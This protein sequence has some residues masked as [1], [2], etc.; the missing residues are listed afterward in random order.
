MESV[1]IGKYVVDAEPEPTPLQGLISDLT[2]HA[3]MSQKAPLQEKVT[4]P[5]YH[6]PMRSVSSVPDYYS[7]NK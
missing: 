3:S 1:N 2:Q 4:S 7:M 6:L 5:D